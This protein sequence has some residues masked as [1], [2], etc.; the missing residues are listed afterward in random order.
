MELGIIIQARMGSDRLPGKT[1]NKIDSNLTILDYVINQIK[2]SKY[3]KKIIVATTSNSEDDKIVSELKDSSVDVF[4]GSS[5]DVL[6]RYYQCAKHFSLDYI[7]RITADNPLIDPKIFD[8]VVEKF[9]DEKPDYAS[10]ALVRTFPYGTEIE[11]LSFETLEKIWK[12]AERTS[13]R[14]HVSVYVKHNPK[15]FKILDIS[16][17]QNISH[18]R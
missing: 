15:K 14:E 17:D 2:H 12:N 16:N 8:L 1:L 3:S 10:N 13:E 4:R 5:D 7:V 18:L 6:D 11:I 9:F